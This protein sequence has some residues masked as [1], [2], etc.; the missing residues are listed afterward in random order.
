M[1]ERPEDLNL[2]VTVVQRIIKESLPDGVIVSKEAR[3]TICRASSVFVLYLTSC[4]VS[5]ANKAKRK[6]LAV[7]DIISAISEMEFDSFVQPLNEILQYRKNN[8]GGQSTKTKSGTKKTETTKAGEGEEGDEEEI[9]EEETEDT[10]GNEEED[11]VNEEEN[12]DD[13]S[14]RKNKKRKT[15]EETDEKDDVEQIEENESDGSETED[16]EHEE[17]TID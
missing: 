8:L 14:G 12:V 11:V 1:A 5:H 17:E 10:N 15:G 3:Q 6:T 13:E 16:S 7:N 4:A 9:E 2:P